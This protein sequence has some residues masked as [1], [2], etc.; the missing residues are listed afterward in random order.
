MTRK[1]E[2]TF[3]VAAP[4]ERAWQVFTDPDEI[5]VVTGRVDPWLLD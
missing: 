2:R 3:T 5:R 4:V 1:W